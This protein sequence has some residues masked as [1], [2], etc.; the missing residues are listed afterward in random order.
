MIALVLPTRLPDMLLG[1]LSEFLKFKVSIGPKL[2]TLVRLF[3]NTNTSG[4]QILVFTW[5]SGLHEDL[6][7]GLRSSSVIWQ[8][9]SAITRFYSVAVITSGS[10]PS[11]S[12]ER[13]WTVRATPV[14]FRVG[15]TSTL[16]IAFV[17]VC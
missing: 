6:L 8:L 15:P 7:I 12:N 1:S 5:R 14:R 3:A 9:V 10:D 17:F 11:S 13:A 4:K 16:C 2:K